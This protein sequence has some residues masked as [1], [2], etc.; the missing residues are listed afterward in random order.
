M[1]QFR[2]PATPP[3]TPPPR[4]PCYPFPATTSH[5]VADRPSSRPRRH[6]ASYHHRLLYF[7]DDL[8][9]HLEPGETQRESAKQLFLVPTDSAPPALHSANPY[10]RFFAEGRGKKWGSSYLFLDC[11]FEGNLPLKRAHSV[12][13]FNSCFIYYEL[14][15]TRHITCIYASLK[16][17]I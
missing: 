1:P 14:T 8:I 3:S 12:T 2:H 4:A 17:N 9:T 10:S 16:A 5:C 7:P 11:D 6:R 13:I 15:R